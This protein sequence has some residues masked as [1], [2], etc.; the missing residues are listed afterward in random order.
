MGRNVN[1][2]YGTNGELNM[3]KDYFETV[4]VDVYKVIY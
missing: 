4:E 1:D 3:H 2:K